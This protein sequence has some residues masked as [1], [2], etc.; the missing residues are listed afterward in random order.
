L[1]G[2]GANVGLT[3]FYSGKFEA[4][5]RTYILQDF[6]CD[7]RFLFFH[8]RAYWKQ[9][10]LNRQYGSATNYIKMQNF[11]DYKIPLPPIAEQRRIAAILDKA[12]GIRRKR[13]EA[14]R[15]TEELGR[16]LFLD[17]FGD[18]VT[19]KKNWVIQN[20]GEIVINKD[21]QRKPVK[22]SDRSSQEKIYPY[23]GATGIIDYVDDYLFDERSLLIEEDGM[24]LVTRNKPIALI[25][26]GKYWVNNHAHVVSEKSSI[27][28]IYLCHFLNYLDIN[29][30]VTGIDQKKL[31]RNNLD[32][33]PVSIPPISLQNQFEIILM[34][35]QKLITQKERFLKESENLFNS[36]LQRA[37]RGEL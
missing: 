35:Q 16:S 3:L 1:P 32:K 23:Y 24:N 31:N 26:M 5:Q 27:N 11:D 21:S 10:N 34:Q 6:E 4:Y 22:E 25:A 20:F 12:D 2:N 7:P 37:F 29:K 13:Q 36:L 17:M 8:L 30:Y 9:I 19:N 28:L 18:P 33:I 14:I 15:L